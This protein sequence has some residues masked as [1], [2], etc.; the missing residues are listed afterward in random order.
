MENLPKDLVEF[1]YE[2]KGGL[3]HR[4]LQKKLIHELKKRFLWVSSICGYQET[5][6]PNKD[7]LTELLIVNKYN[8]R[9]SKN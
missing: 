3:D 7:F 6:L 8:L 2:L 5:L 1:I 4:E 9:V